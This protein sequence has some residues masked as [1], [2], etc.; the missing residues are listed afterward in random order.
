MMDVLGMPS[1]CVKGCGNYWKGNR[2]SDGIKYHVFPKDPKRSAEWLKCINQDFDSEK[3]SK[4]RICSQHFSEKCYNRDLQN[5]LLGLPIRKK[6]HHDAVPDTNLP[7]ERI[8]CESNFSLSDEYE[9]VWNSKTLFLNN[10]RRNFNIKQEDCG[11]S[12]SEIPV[13]LT[14]YSNEDEQYIKIKENYPLINE[15]HNETNDQ[16]IDC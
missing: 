7:F 11:V 5:E 1:C 4:M 9:N 15:N 10:T 8:I 16:E 13:A 6:L 3:I 2:K 12:S 14:T